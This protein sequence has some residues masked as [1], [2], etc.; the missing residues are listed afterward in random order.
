M[1]RRQRIGRA[2]Y[3]VP[4]R[5]SRGEVATAVAVA[6]GIVLGAVVLV[7]MLRPGGDPYSGGIANRQPRATWLVVGAI[8]AALV[9]VAATL[10]ARHGIMARRKAVVPTVL[11]VAVIGAVALAGLWPGGLLRHAPALPEAPGGTVPVEVP[12]DQT[13]TTTAPAATTAPSTTAAAPTSTTPAT[14][15]TSSATGSP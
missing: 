1:S 9:G 10:R 14:S 7:W 2:R 5:R 4:R 3:V 8:V 13:E 15:A 12:T 6:V 11:V